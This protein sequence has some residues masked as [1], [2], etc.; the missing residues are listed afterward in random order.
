PGLDPG[1]PAGTGEA[2]TLLSAGPVSV[3]MPG[4]SPGMT[5]EGPRD[6][7]LLSAAR[8]YPDAYGDKPGHDGKGLHRTAKMRIAGADGD[9]LPPRIAHGTVGRIRSSP[10]RSNMTLILASRPNV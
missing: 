9:R 5:W 6:D 8:S 7:T 4:S 10:A 1:I 2:G 3:G